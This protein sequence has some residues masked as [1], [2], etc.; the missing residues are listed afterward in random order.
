MKSYK[1]L[2]FATALGAAVFS[3]CTDDFAEMNQDP[4]AVTSPNVGYLFANGVNQFEPMGYTY[5]FYN[6]PMMYS[7]NQMAVPT[8]GMTT[9]IL[10]TTA[11]GDQGTQYIN[12]LRYLRDI[13]NQLEQLPAEEAESFA[14][15]KAAVE[16]LTIYL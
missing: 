10:T 14:S 6:A 2:L 5:W 8:G 7:W 12:T 4:T 11:T 13:E 1:S 9:G 16:V 15:Y 3:G